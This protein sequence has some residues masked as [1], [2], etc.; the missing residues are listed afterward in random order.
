MDVWE[1]INKIQEAITTINHNSTTLQI[2][3]AVLK[4]QVGN[5]VWLTRAFLITFI[6]LIGT[7]FWQLILMRKNG[8]KK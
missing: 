7:Q 6:G 5:L 4:D 8:K 1:T 2:D 3:V